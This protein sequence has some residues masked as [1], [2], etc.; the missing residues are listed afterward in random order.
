MATLR[1]Y[2]TGSHLISVGDFIKADKSCISR[3]VAKVSRA[4]AGLAPEYIYMPRNRLE[5]LDCQNK[6]YEILQFPQVIGAID[7]THVKV[8]SPGR[9]DA[10]VF[11]NRKG[12][13]SLNVQAVTS[14]DYL[15]RDIVA[16]WPGSTHDSTI[17][18]NSRLK[19]RF[20][21][22]EF[23][24]CI[25]L[26]KLFFKLNYKKESVILPIYTFNRK[27]YYIY[28]QVTAGI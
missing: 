8:Q 7:G 12:F 18:N 22:G 28:F 14:A 6:F 16:R 17:F 13:F 20:D 1:T 27:N 23:S 2:A 9:E 21:N 5:I 24:G 10:E 3:I 25:L 26:G 15:F 11:R 19:Y 4:I